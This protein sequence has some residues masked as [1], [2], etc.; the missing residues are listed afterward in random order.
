MR[1]SL[2]AVFCFFFF[3]HKVRSSGK[4]EKRKKITNLPRGTSRRV[5]ETSSGGPVHTNVGSDGDLT[6]VLL[7]AVDGSLEEVVVADGL[8]LG[9]EE[10]GTCL[11]TITNRQIL[12]K[13]QKNKE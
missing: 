2:T 13:S 9:G 11:S 4:K 6:E 8:S 7:R 5:G 10:S 12:T 1:K 3:F